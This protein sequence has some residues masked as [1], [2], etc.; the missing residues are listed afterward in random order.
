MNKYRNYTIRLIL[1]SPIITPFQ[2]D[3]LFG[4]ICWAINYLKWDDKREVEDFLA[5]YDQKK[6][7][8]L[9]SNG[10]PKDYLP[11]PI[12][13][14]IL[15]EELES[16]FGKENRKENSYKIKTI[17]RAE[18]IRKDDLLQIIK[19][20]ISPEILFRK[21]AKNFEKEEKKRKKRGKK[22]VVYHNTI[23][24][25]TNRVTTG[26]YEQEETFYAP[27]FNEFEIYLKTNYFN[28]DDLRRIFEFISMGGF[29]KDKS[30]GKGRFKFSII[31][32]TD[33]KDSDNPNG[34]MTL[35]SYI[36]HS[37]A[38]TKGYYEIL[39]KYGKLGGDFAMGSAEVDNNPFKKP[40]IMFR[41]G[42]TFYDS[43]YDKS[44]IYGSLLKDVHKNPKIRHY[45]Y[46]FPLGINME[47][48]NNEQI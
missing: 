12:T 24:R 5:L 20:Q 3:T 35:S 4:H 15:Q 21:L 6:P 23:N 45:G 37:E 11:K 13:R 30:I 46:A 36:P 29:G 18:L 47:E 28:K 40:L 9:I 33:L 41:A 1:K 42:S 38:P 32:G 26:L 43:D 19:G 7:P 17:K 22:E 14:P 39:L 2:S 31:E 34:F 10:F 8:L 48:E 44:K 27:D 25:V 16:I